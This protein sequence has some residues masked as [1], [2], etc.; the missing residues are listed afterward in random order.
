MSSRCGLIAGVCYRAS[1][2]RKGAALLRQYIERK[3]NPH[4]HNRPGRGARGRGAAL[5]GLGARGYFEGVTEVDEESDVSQL[6]Y[7]KDC[8]ETDLLSHLS[9]VGEIEHRTAR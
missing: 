9:V 3:L 6:L 7:P 8:R 4:E 2:N 5:P 1:D